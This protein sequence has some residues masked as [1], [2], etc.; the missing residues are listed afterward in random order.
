MPALARLAAP[1]ALLAAACVTT[2]S[3]EEVLAT[4]YRTPRQTFHTL[5][6]G[7]RADLPGLEYAC[8]STGFRARHGLSQL[9]YRE[10]RDDVLEHELAFWL[11]IPAAEVLAEVPLAPD[12]VRL[13]CRSHGT[14]FALELVREDFWQAWGGPELLADEPLG[15]GRFAERVEVFEDP[16]GRVVLSGFALAPGDLA[17]RGPED[18]AERLTELRSGREWKLDQIAGLANP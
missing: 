15:A 18:L 7:V 1:L 13:E 14:D 3:P 10:F 12:R 5:Q 8:L 17:A 9:A 11:G 16:A 6:V 2:P 4:G